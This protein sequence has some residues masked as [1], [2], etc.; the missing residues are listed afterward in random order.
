MEGSGGVF[1]IYKNETCF[2]A[3]VVVVDDASNPM[4]CP[5]NKG[6]FLGSRVGQQHMGPQSRGFPTC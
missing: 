1:E 6:F 3:V 2:L 4:A 5:V